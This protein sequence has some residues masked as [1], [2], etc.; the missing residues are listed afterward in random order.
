MKCP[1]S[2]DYETTGWHAICNGYLLKETVTSW[3]Q[4]LDTDNFYTK[5]KALMPWWDK[6]LMLMVRVWGGVMCIICYPRT[7]YTST[8]LT[9]RLH[10]AQSFLKSLVS[11]L[12]IKCQHFMETASSLLLYLS[13]S[14]ARSIHSMYILPPSQFFKIHCNII[15]PSKPRSPKWPLSLGSG[16]PTN[17]LYAS[18][19]P[20][21]HVTCPLPSHSFLF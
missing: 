19:L 3:L 21:I 7:M 17:S 5:T 4:T 13:L 10:G 18:L 14:S 16:F 2:I 1:L 20:P 11:Q 8:D 15:L 6:H 9:G 12:G